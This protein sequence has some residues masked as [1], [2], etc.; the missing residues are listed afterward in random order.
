MFAGRTNANLAYTN[1]FA[2]PGLLGEDISLM[3]LWMV[4]SIESVRSRTGIL[5]GESNRY[6][7]H[8]CSGEYLA[9]YMTV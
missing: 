8:H 2:L 6:T 1:I 9:V 4:V 5:K 7:C 3:F